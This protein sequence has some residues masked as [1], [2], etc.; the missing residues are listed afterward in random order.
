MAGTKKKTRA[1]IAKAGRKK[2]ARR[3]KADPVLPR[4]RLTAEVNA[5]G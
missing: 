1:P 4:V 2:A 5:G 3:S